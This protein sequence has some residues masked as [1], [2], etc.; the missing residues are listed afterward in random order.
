MSKFKVGQRVLVRKPKKLGALT[1]RWIE[2]M[3]LEHNT[4]QVIGFI[5]EEGDIT[6]R[7]GSGFYF[8]RLWL[9]PVGELSEA[10]YGE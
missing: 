9:T 2:A 8:S 5:D 6:F 1:C 4:I 7:V 10:I 3:D